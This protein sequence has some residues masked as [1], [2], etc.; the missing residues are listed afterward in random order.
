MVSGGGTPSVPTDLALPQSDP[1][2]APRTDSSPAG[3]PR[4]ADDSALAATLAAGAGHVLLGLRSEH[5][6]SAPRDLARIGDAGAQRYLAAALRHHRPADALLSE[7]GTDDTGR[8]D[9]SR[10]W[11]IDPL[12]GTREF[13]EEGRND[14]AVHVALWEEG[15][16]TAAA[17]ALPARGTVLTTD[18]TPRTARRAEGS[19][20]GPRLAV[21]RSRPP[22]LIA[23]LARLLDARLVPMG[24]AGVKIAAV[25]EGTADAYVHAGG[26]YEWDSAAPVAVAMAR[27]LH[28]SRIDGSPLRYNQ[29][30]PW[31]PDLVV[32]HPED[33]DR[34]LAALAD[35]TPPATETP[36]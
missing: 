30:R 20:R 25:I 18:P 22:A 24:S 5:A 17:V 21:S 1:Q 27:G 26:Q 19:G 23:P 36:S 32:C 10:V 33:R 7:E 31:L 15:R 9:A 8:L 35:V 29:A 3:T 6:G 12:D 13:S 11:I 28:A 16:L 4:I 2:S 34:I 14:W